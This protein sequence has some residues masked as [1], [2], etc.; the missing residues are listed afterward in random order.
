MTTEDNRPPPSDESGPDPKEEAAM[1]VERAREAVI[2]CARS[3]VRV[4]QFHRGSMVA[5]KCI[6]PALDELD[7][8]LA[9]QKGA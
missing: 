5:I 8:A 7:A 1:R 6:E 9:A 4:N 3:V 2:E